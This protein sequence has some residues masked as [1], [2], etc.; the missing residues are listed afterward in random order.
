MNND[1]NNSLEFI[2]TTISEDSIDSS[3]IPVDETSED[4]DIKH[5]PKKV[6]KSTG[7]EK[8]LW[9]VARKYKTLFDK[10]IV[11][12]IDESEEDRKS[13]ENAYEQL[14][15]NRHWQLDANVYQSLSKMQ[16]TRDAKVALEGTTETERLRMIAWEVKTRLQPIIFITGDSTVEMEI[17]NMHDTTAVRIIEGDNKEILVED[18]VI[19]DKGVAIL[20][21]LPLRKISKQQKKQMKQEII[22]QF[23]GKSFTLSE[24]NEIFDSINADLISLMTR[25]GE[26]LLL[27]QKEG[28]YKIIPLAETTEKIDHSILVSQS[29]TITPKRKKRED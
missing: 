21:D 1:G 19:V 10:G 25:E 5:S 23:G 15:T 26:L 18:N 9:E 22:K 4:R 13:V 3:S 24:M 17:F 29:L 8:K 28:K 7:V 6:K 2:I 27:K 14:S 11:P 16:R 12:Q 20:D